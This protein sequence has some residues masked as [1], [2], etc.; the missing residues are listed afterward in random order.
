MAGLELAEDGRLREL[1]HGIRRPSFFPGD[2]LST[3]HENA[4]LLMRLYELR[5]EAKLREARDWVTRSFNPGSPE[6]FAAVLGSEHSTKVR[7]VMGYWDMAAAFVVHGAIDAPM[8]HATSGEMLAAFCKVEH[9]L[10]EVR[11][12]TG[13][14]GLLAHVEQV[15]AEW[16]GAKERMAGMREYFAGL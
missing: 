14:P 6:D 11:E 15:A 1:S 16:P 5:R 7:M 3:P 4:D 2:S 12:H 10:A 9:M 13:Q 8:F